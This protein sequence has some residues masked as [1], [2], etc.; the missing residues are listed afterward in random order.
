MNLSVSLK[1]ICLYNADLVFRNVKFIEYK[2]LVSPLGGV[3]EQGVIYATVN[4]I[5]IVFTCVKHF[6]VQVKI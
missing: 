6:I 1:R 4:Y 3:F 5:G 2:V